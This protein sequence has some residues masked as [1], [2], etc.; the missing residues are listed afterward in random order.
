M[1]QLLTPDD[2]QALG[3]GGTGL[4]SLAAKVV[5]DMQ[6][7]D[8]VHFLSAR[9]WSLHYTFIRE[10]IY[11]EPQLDRCD[12]AQAAAFEAGW[13]EFSD[14]EYFQTEGRRFLLATLVR[15]GGSGVQT[16]EFDR[17]DVITAE[18]MRRA[19]FAVAARTPRPSA[20]AVRAQGRQVAALK[21]IEGTVPLLEPNAPFRG[22]T[23]QPITPGVGFG[24][25]RFVPAAELAQARLG[26]G[27]HRGHRR[28]AQ[29]RAAGGR[30]R[31]PRPSRRPCPTWAC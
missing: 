30:A 7:G 25:L 19:F 8:A 6:A 4:D 24:V 17:A 1:R 18:Q 21:A 12:P 31:S 27:R 14:R 9:Q 28:R 22:L 10:R 13:R 15:Y 20:W 3:E 23:F 2:V 29:R 26:P 11:G 16:L 5:V